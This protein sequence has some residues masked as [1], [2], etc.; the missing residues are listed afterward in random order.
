MKPVAAAV[1]FLCA[2]VAAAGPAAASACDT[3]VAACPSSTGSGAAGAACGSCGASSFYGD[4]SALGA[5]ILLGIGS[6][7]A[8][9]LFRAAR[10]RNRGRSPRA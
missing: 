10:E 9:G 7:A 4:A 8:E 6:V 1:A 3:A 5:G 2:S